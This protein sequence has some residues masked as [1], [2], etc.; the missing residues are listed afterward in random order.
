MNTE[1]L[2]TLPGRF[3]VLGSRITS[4]TL[5]FRDDNNG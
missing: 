3:R 2:A 4:L 5:G 1:R